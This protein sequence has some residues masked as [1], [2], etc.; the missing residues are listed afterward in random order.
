M[1]KTSDRTTAKLCVP[2]HSESLSLPWEQ[3]IVVWF[4]SLLW[5]CHIAC[6]LCHKCQEASVAPGWV[7][8]RRG[9]AGPRTMP[10]GLFQEPL[11]DLAGK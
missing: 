6:L 7:Q 1:S 2:L 3:I 4:F 8:W 10:H 5:E 9:E 11:G